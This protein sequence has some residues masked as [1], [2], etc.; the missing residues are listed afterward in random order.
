MFEGGRTAPLFYAQAPSFVP[1]RHGR[2]GC[3]RLRDRRRR[4][5]DPA[6]DCRSPPVR[7]IDWAEATPLVERLEQA[8]PESL[9]AIPPS[10]R[11][12]R[13][14]GWLANRRKELAA[15]V[16]QG[17]GDAVVNLLLF[18]TSFTNEPRITSSLLQ[19]LDQRWKAGDQ[20]VQDTLVRHYQRRAADLV[21]AAADPG[22]GERIR[23]VRRVLA[24][25]GHDLVHRGGAPLV[26]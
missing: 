15:R 8:L 23:E 9:R 12:A 16:A 13:W 1:R 6:D 3:E 11:P 24:M 7:P 5:A 10:E 21:A 20:S 22:A 2:H 26:D 25:N 19:E 4:T 18:G 14:P 17:D